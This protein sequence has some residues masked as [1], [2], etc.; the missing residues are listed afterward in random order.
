M[1]RCKFCGI[2]VQGKSLGG[3]TSTC[4]QNPKW[5]QNIEPWIN[6]GKAKKKPKH[7]V[8]CKNCGKET[9]NPVFCSTNCS[10]SYNNKQRI[11]KTCNCINCNTVMIGFE[12]ADRKYCSKKCEAE[13]RWNAV[14][15]ENKI[16]S[17][18]L[19]GSA[20]KKYMHKKYHECFLCGINETWNNKPLVLQVDH[21]DGNSDNNKLENLR[22]ICPNCHTQTETFC[23]RNFKNAKR[24]QYLRR[25][26]RKVL[27][28]E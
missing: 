19:S 14:D 25:Y 11:K 7:I 17:G 13:Y 21:T 10:A 4:K 8:T 6:A 20:S 28:A 2:E 12:A 1:G 18:L 3:H 9:E 22:L 26:K 5:R 15:R 16:K 24:N 27:Y 23:Q